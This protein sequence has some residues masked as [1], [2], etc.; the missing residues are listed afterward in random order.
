MQLSFDLQPR[1]LGAELGEKC[2]ERA[3]RVAGFDREGARKFVLSQLVRFGQMSGEDLVD[4][5][6]EHGFRAPDARAFGPIFSKL[7]RDK[8]IR[9]IRSDLPRKRGNGT[10]GG[11]LYGLAL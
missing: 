2:L 1:A 5:A 10:S 9:V 6:T 7:L 3:E 8:Q 4:A 11:R